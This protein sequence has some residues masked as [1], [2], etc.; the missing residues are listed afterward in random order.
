MED[1]NAT[2][3]STQLDDS[4]ATGESRTEEA[5][6]ADIIR[7][8]EFLSDEESLPDEQVPQLDAEYSDD[9]D[10]EESDGAGS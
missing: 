3:D 2:P 5:M 10:P 4:V 9:E 1:T 7:N 8:T 6:L